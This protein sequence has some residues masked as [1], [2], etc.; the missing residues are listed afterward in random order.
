GVLPVGQNGCDLACSASC[1]RL[2]AAR[3]GVRENTNFA[4]RL[5]RFRDFKVAAQNIS[6]SENQKSR[7]PSPV[8]PR[9]EGRYVQSSP[10]VRRDA[11]DAKARRRCALTRTAK[12]C[13]PGPPTLGSS[14]ARRSRGDGG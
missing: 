6:L 9:E 5:N 3:I 2:R 14:P 4:N 8:P 12:A 11:M 13:G 1:R 10:D 7:I